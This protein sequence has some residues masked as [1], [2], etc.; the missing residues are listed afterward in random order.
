MRRW[1]DES[2]AFIIFNFDNAD[3]RLTAPL[4]EGIWKKIVDSSEDMWNGPGTFLPERLT[5]GEEMTVRSNSLAL[6]IKSIR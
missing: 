2:N 4:T 1:K 3:V 6:Y 5:Q